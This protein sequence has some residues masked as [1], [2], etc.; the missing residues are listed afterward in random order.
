MTE[1]IKVQGPF[2]SL[3]KS[4][5]G[6]IISTVITGVLTTLLVAWLTGHLGE[7][8][9]SKSEVKSKIALTLEEY[10]NGVNS[11]TFDA[12]KYFS[13]RVDR[14][15]QMFDTSPQKINDY[16]NGLF[17]KQF[18]N[19][20]MRFDNSTLSI[21]KMETGEYKA[22]VIM[23]SDYFDTKKKKQFSNYRTRVE[24]RFDDNIR[25]KYFRQFYD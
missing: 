6:K 13:P 10:S 3:L 2:L 17:Y 12:Y 19:A 25:I 5:T 4:T 21:E 11:N 15:F 9:L 1:N 14:F 20:V 16:V 7:K 18:K 23:Y 22:M 24:L 8:E